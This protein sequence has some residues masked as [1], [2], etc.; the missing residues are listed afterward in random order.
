MVGFGYRGHGPSHADAVGPHGGNSVLALSVQDRHAQSLAVLSAQL[1]DVAGLD[2][3]GHPQGSPARGA[4]RAVQDSPDVDPVV[5]GHVPFHVH[6]GQVHVVLIGPGGHARAAPQGVVGVD[7]QVGDPDG[8]QA[9]RGGAQR[10]P[11]LVGLSRH[12][13]DGPCGVGEF[14]FQERVVASQQ[15]QGQGSVHSVDEGFDLVNWRVAGLGEGGDGADSRRGEGLRVIAAG[16]VLH[17]SGC[18]GS[19]LHVGRVPAAL[20]DRHV[21]LAGVGLDHELDRGASAHGARRCLHGLGIEVEAPEG[22]QVGVVVEVE[23]TVQPGVVQIERVRVLHGELPY[24]QQARLGAGLVTELPLD[25]VPDLGELPVRA[26]LQ[27]QGGEDFLVGHPEGQV[28]ALTVGETEHL[29][30]YGL[31][32]ARGLPQR[33]RVHGR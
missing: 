14:L 12:D 20:A 22:P 10:G 23:R 25:L 4:S 28:G 18:G 24:T 1:E 29:L 16:P 11:D 21:V 17:G 7:R 26:Q 5:N 19:P 27:G 2:A 32:A 33:S 13:V 3:A 8:A 6:A 15:D 9:A 31:P 30:T